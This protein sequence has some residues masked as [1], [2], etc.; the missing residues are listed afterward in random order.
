[1]NHTLCSILG[2]VLIEDQDQRTEQRPELEMHILMLV[3]PDDPMIGVVPTILDRHQ[4]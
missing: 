1:M 3:D 4:W 2:C